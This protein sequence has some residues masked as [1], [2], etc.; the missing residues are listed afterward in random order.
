MNRF[1]NSTVFLMFLLMSGLINAD[2]RDTATERLLSLSADSPSL[3]IPRAD[4]TIASERIR[5]DRL[6]VYY[7]MGSDGAKATFS[8]YINSSGVCKAVDDCL[9]MSLKNQSYK[10][11][12]ELARTD[13]GL[14]KVAHFYLDKVMG[15]PIFQTNVLASVIVNGHWFD[16]HLSSAGTERPELKPLLELLKT[17]SIRQ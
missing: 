9:S 16:I 17:F 8:V 10:D 5:Q 4:W 14:F 7:L 6:V 15:K 13:I 2:V 3:V 12:R 11:A 1:F